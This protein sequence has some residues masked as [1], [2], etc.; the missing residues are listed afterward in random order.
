MLRWGVI[1]LGV[2]SAIVVLI[3]PSVFLYYGEG[4][5]FSRNQ[6]QTI[7]QILDGPVEKLVYDFANFHVHPRVYWWLAQR[8]NSL[9]ETVLLE[10]TV[11]Y[12]I[13]GGALYFGAGLCFGGLLSL[14]KL[15][16][17][18]LAG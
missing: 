2:H 10:Q 12:L 17:R 14:G 16:R 6:A 1:L 4:F 8:L 3:A 7:H 13:F 15:R 5:L 18:R 11:L 9:D